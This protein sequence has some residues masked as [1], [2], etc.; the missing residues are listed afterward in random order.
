S[1]RCV[2]VQRASL[3]P[4][5]TVPN[6]AV[7]RE[8]DH[9]FVYLAFDQEKKGTTNLLHKYRVE[10]GSQNEQQTQIKFSNQPKE[11][12]HLVSKNVAI[13]ENERKKRTGAVLE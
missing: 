3:T 2:V 11:S 4:Q 7:L 5:L 1:V 8:E 10:L 13:V 12:L 6:S 9:A